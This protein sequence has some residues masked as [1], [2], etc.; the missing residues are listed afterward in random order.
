[1]QDQTFVTFTLTCKTLKWCAIGFGDS[2]PNA[3]IIRMSTSNNIV[4][5]EDMLAKPGAG[6]VEPRLDS[7]QDVTLMQGWQNGTH[8]FGQFQRKLVTDDDADYPIPVLREISMIW[9]LGNGDTS[10]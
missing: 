6:Y 1:M 9:A 5:I 8:T 7:E 3:D 2:M 10:K 4:V